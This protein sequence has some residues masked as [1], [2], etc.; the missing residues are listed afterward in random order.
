MNNYSAIKL[1]L[2]EQLRIAANLIYVMC[3]LG[4]FGFLFLCNLDG[5]CDFL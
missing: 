5:K 3:V 4:I 1:L 2:N